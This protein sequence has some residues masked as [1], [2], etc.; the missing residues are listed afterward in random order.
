[1]MA[2]L[3]EKGLPDDYV[4]QL[5]DDRLLL[6]IDYLRGSYGPAIINTWANG[7]PR[8]ESG[9]REDQMTYFSD[10]SQHAYGRAVDLIFRRSS[11][12]Q[13]R[14]DFSAG[15]HHTFLIENRMKVTLER[16]VEWLHVD[17]R[18]NHDWVNFFGED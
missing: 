1:M 6:L 12:D 4:Y 3:E 8:Q 15:V 16:G 14:A 10:T 5:F 7:G 11:A 9:L 18:N 2:T 13:I 17:V